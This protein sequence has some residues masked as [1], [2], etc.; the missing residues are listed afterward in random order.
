LRQF[1]QLG[2]DRGWSPMLFALPSG[3]RSPGK[4]MVPLRARPEPLVTT[5]SAGLEGAITIRTLPQKYTEQVQTGFGEVTIALS[6]SPVVLQCTSLISAFR[7]VQMSF[8]SW[9]A[10]TNVKVN[11]S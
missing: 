4:R 5:D 3:A 10:I 2:E 11:E 1:G 8:S 6:P 9:L 7:S